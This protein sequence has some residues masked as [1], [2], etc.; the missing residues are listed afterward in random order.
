M[1]VPDEAGLRLSDEK[2]QPG[3][4]CRTGLLAPL[5]VL[6]VTGMLAGAVAGAARDV[7]GSPGAFGL[8]TAALRGFGKV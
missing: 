3:R 2:T 6:L 8:S 1:V 7:M 4:T 5:G